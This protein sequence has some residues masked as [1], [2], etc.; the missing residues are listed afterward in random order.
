M[1]YIV[2]STESAPGSDDYGEM[3]AYS[4]P[5][6]EKAEAKLLEWGY[7]PQ[8]GPHWERYGGFHNEQ[9]AVLLPIDKEF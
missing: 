5:S 2:V 1:K 9:T 7:K 8:G 6:K 3:K 4:F